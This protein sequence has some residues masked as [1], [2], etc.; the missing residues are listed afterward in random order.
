MRN[1]ALYAGGPSLAAYGWFWRYQAVWAWSFP[2]FAL[3][4]CNHALGA[5]F[6]VGSGASGPEDWPSF[7]GSITLAWSVRNFW[8]RVWHQTMRR[9]RQY[10]RPVRLFIK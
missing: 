7:M 10:H 6:S 5:A 3:G 1:P 8:G 2:M 9:V 4:A